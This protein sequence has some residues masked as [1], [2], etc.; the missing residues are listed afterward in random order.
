[1]SVDVTVEEEIAR[2]P[3]EVAR[4]AMD[5][6]NDMRWIAALTSVRALGDGPV[7]PGTRVE[8]T[9]SF[10]GRRMEYV[11]EIVELE[12]ERRLAMRS[13]RAPFPMTVEYEFDPAAVGALARI[14]TTGE[15]GRFYATAG[16]L[17]GAMVRRGVR[18]DL[19]KLKRVLEA[20]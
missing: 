7:G 19:R 16:P 4:F 12:P 20:T 11:L 10:L 5:P 13:V 3:E 2:P 9:A 17:L 1:V 15:P 8:R 18:R 6:G 14:R